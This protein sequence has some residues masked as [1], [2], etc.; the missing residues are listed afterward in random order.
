[1]T[2]CL[3]ISANYSRTEAPKFTLSYLS[4]ELR[5]TLTDN[6]TPL[7]AASSKQGRPGRC[8]PILIQPL[9]PLRLLREP[10]KTVSE[11]DLGGGLARKLYIRVAGESPKLVNLK[12]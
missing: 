4:S 8:T 9:P 1:M 10:S 3:V 12:T 5:D 2:L 11:M 7:L 6:G